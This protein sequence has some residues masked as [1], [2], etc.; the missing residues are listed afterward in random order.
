MAL[1]A[2]AVA[3]LL[4]LAWPASAQHAGHGKA[5]VPRA[6]LGASAAFANDGALWAVGALG[7]HVVWRVSP[8]SGAS[9]S[10]PAVV[11]G[12]PEPVAADGDSRPKIVVGKSG[13]LFVTWTRPLALPYTGEVRFSRSLDGGVHWSKPVTVHTDR[14]QITHRFDAMAVDRQGKLFI[15]WIDKRDQ[16]QAK[17][18]GEPYRGAAIYFAVSDDDGASFRGDFKLAEHSCECCRIALLARSDTGVTALWRHVF[19]PNIRDHAIADLYAD[20]SASEIRRASFDD[21]AID[22]CPHHGPSLARDSDGTL[23]AVWFHLGKHEPGVTYGRL[24]DGKVEAQ[25]RL[26]GDGAA[27]ADI[28]VDGQRLLLVW[29]E[30]DGQRTWLRAQR[31]DDA[32]AHWRDLTLADTGDMSDQPRA[33]VH[34][35]RFHVFWNTR[36]RPWQVVAV[37]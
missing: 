20:G 29:K 15:A 2:L 17:A 30:F 24:L 22:A 5:A 9:W 31:S 37:P 21:W 32:G 7:E 10:A 16:V 4:A 23:H 8:D 26:G 25:R 33:L 34:D 3:W 28:A 6:D 13:Q 19:A 27:H 18:A 36:E 11:N 1:R 12:E 14:Q 35:G